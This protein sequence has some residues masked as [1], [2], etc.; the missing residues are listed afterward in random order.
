MRLL[1]LLLLTGCGPPWWAWECPQNEPVGNW[2][3]CQDGRGCPDLELTRDTHAASCSGGDGFNC[4][5]YGCEAGTILVLDDGYTTT[6]KYFDGNGQLVGVHE[7]YDWRQCVA[8]G[9]WQHSLDYGE[10]VECAE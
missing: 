5:E 1:P 2:W 8:D 4:F 3:G 9:D 6:S 10:P 7:L